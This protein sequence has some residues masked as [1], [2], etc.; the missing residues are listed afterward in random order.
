MKKNIA[1]LG[2]MCAGCAANVERKLNALDGV[3]T[4]AVN[5]PTR[6]VLIDYDEKLVTLPQMKEALAHIGYDMVIEEDRNLEALERRALTQLWCKVLLSWLFA[7]L[8]MSVSMGWVMKELPEAHRNQLCFIIAL[9]NLVYCG[10][11]FFVNAWRQL[12]HVSANMDTLVALS[13]GISFLFSTFNT[14]WGD[15]FWSQYGIE[16]HSLPWFLLIF[17]QRKRLQSDSCLRIGR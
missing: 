8:V 4:A 1:V 14:F 11:Q 6:T 5:L 15:T 7:L 16:S 13:T 10:R 2:M 17:H 3:S 12:T 9:L